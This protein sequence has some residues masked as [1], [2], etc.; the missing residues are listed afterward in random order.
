MT[1]AAATAGQVLGRFK[2]EIGLLLSLAGLF[3]VTASPF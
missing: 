3:A 1:Q 2:V